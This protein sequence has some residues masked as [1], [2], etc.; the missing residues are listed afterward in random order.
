M[1]VGMLGVPIALLFI[2]VLTVHESQ[3]R[4]RVHPVADAPD[5]APAL[6]VVSR[7]ARCECMHA[8]IE[9]RDVC[10]VSRCCCGRFVYG[11]GLADEQSLA[12]AQRAFAATGSQAD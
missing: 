3:L 12:G 8:L 11:G 5:G 2:A 9:H 1:L 7:Q 6:R 4:R 10:C